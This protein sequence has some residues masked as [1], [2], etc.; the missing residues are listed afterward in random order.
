MRDRRGT[1][2]V[3]LAPALAAAATRVAAGGADADLVPEPVLPTHSPVTDTSSDLTSPERLVWLALGATI[4]LAVALL[5]SLSMPLLRW[6]RV[7]RVL[8]R[9]GLTAAEGWA[10]MLSDRSSVG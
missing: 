10:E 3:W 7:H 2:H 8:R 4:M 1:S 6:W 5:W 9:P